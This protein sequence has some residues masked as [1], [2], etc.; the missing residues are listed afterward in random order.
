MANTSAQTS[1]FGIMSAHPVSLI[2]GITNLF[3]RQKRR[4]ELAKIYSDLLC[5]DDHILRDIGMTRLDI[6]RMREGLF[7]N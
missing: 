6:I 3:R 4:E 5:A 2:L 7:R 1:M